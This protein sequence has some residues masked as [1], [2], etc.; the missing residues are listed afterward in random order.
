MDVKKPLPR[1]KVEAMLFAIPKFEASRLRLGV[2]EGDNHDRVAPVRYEAA[3]VGKPTITR[4][5]SSTY[6]PI[7][8]LNSQE[9]SNSWNQSFM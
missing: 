1:D 3:L 6:L 8:S 7:V 5:G 2:P 4:Q 9:G